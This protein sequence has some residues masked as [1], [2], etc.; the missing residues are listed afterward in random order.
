MGFFF[1]VAIWMIGTIVLSH[2]GYG[3]PQN[4]L[5]LRIALRTG[6]MDRVVHHGRVDRAG[7]ISFGSMDL[8]NFAP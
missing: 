2:V 5:N 1:G 3:L 8:R 7:F 4:I 6:A